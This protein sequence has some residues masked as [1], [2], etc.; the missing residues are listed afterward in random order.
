MPSQHTSIHVATSWASFNCLVLNTRR[1][2]QQANKFGCITSHGYDC[3]YTDVNP[4]PVDGRQHLHDLDAL[5][6]A[7]EVLHPHPCVPLKVRN[8]V[9]GL[10]PQPET[11]PNERSHGTRCFHE[12]GG[13]TDK[14]FSCS[15]H[16]Q[17]SSICISL[18]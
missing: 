16:G 8:I 9:D 18:S 13:A 14:P 15:Y 10:G 7:R 12:H 17:S 5:V 1:P 3:E 11:H 2:I 4:V 6:L